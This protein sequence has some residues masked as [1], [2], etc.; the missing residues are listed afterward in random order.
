MNH[1]EQ[2]KNLSEAG[3]QCYNEHLKMLDKFPMEYTV[4][5]A[6]EGFCVSE[7]SGIPDPLSLI[8]SLTE[9]DKKIVHTVVAAHSQ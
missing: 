9:K 4:K 7:F 5:T 2:A 1:I 8:T 3:I 6:Q